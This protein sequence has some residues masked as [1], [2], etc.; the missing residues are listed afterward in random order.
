MAVKGKFTE[1][2]HPRGHGGKFIKGLPR[3]QTKKDRD[4]ATNTLARFRH[5]VLGPQAARDYHQTHGLGDRE[6]LTIRRYLG[7]GYERVNA[8]MREGRDHPDIAGV[9]STF[10]PLQHDLVVAR[11]LDP[12]AFGLDSPDRLR[13][14]VG[15][16]ITD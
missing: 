12:E 2:L 16:K 4:R 11:H 13:G 8:A 10:R 9:R 15:R 14:L 5:H 6:R 3:L 7:G 1:N